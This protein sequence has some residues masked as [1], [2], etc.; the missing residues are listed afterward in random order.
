MA[1]FENLLGQLPQLPIISLLRSQAVA[2]AA[3]NALHILG[4]GM[5][6][7][8]T[9]PLDLGILRAPG[10]AWARTVDGPL[11]RLAITAFLFTVMTGLL[12][13]SVRPFDYLNNDAFLVKLSLLLLA[14]L[15]ALLFQRVRAPEVR[16]IQAGLS[17]ALWLVVLFAGRWIGFIQ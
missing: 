2:Y 5:F 4:L 6:L 16:R 15:N 3:V 11:R 7:G 17:L 12:L 9:L 8:A 14:G 13:F 10:F 1:D